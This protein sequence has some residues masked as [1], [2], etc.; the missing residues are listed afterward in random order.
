MQQ[1]IPKRSKLESKYFKPGQS[2]T[3]TINLMSPLQIT[4]LLLSPI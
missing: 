1:N 4:S 2:F 3:M